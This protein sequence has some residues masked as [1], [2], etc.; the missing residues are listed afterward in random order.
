MYGA[1]SSLRATGETVINAL[2]EKAKVF[3]EH[4]SDG[5]AG[6]GWKIWEVSSN[7]FR[8]TIDELIVRKAMYV[9]ELVISKIRAIAGIIMVSPANGKIKEV[10]RTADNDGWICTIEGDNLFV[11]GDFVRC[12][13][14]HNGA[15]KDY[16]LRVR[17][18]DGQDI[19]LDEDSDYL[20]QRE[21]QAGDELVL[22]GSEVE[23]RQDY[24][25]ISADGVTAPKIEVHDK[26]SKRYDLTE[27]SN[28]T[29]RVILG[30]L[31]DFS[32]PTF[33]ELSGYGLFADNVYLKGKFLFRYTQP[34]DDGGTQTEYKTID[35]L[36]EVS[37]GKLR[38]EI[39]SE[40]LS[41]D[42]ISKFANPAFNEG[43]DKWQ[44]EGATAFK[45]GD[46]YGVR[47]ANG[48]IYQ[49]I[50]DMTK[51]SSS[52]GMAVLMETKPVHIKI[53]Y[54]RNT[55]DGKLNVSV[56][57]SMNGIMAGS[58]TGKIGFDGEITD[59]GS[60]VEIIYPTSDFSTPSTGT[61]GKK[62]ELD[63][64]SEFNWL[65]P[66]KFEVTGEVDIYMVILS[67]SPIKV[68]REK[69]SSLIKQ[70]DR[71]VQ[72][73]TQHVDKDGNIINGGFVSTTD[74]NDF[75]DGLNG[76]FDDYLSTNATIQQWNGF[77]TQYVK[78]GQLITKADMGV[79]ITTDDLG[80]AMS[81]AQIN[82]DQITFTAKNFT[83]WGDEKK[84]DKL[85]SVNEYGTMET[86]GF[87]NGGLS[88]MK[89]TIINR[90]NI[91]KYFNY[92]DGD[93]AIEI[94]RI[95]TQPKLEL[96]IKW[97]VFEETDSKTKF[98]E[99]STVYISLPSLMLGY[100]DQ[101]KATPIQS[102]QNADKVRKFIGNDLY[103]YNNTDIEIEVYGYI[104]YE[105]DSTSTTNTANKVMRKANT[106]MDQT[107]KSDGVYD[108][109]EGGYIVP[110]ATRPYDDSSLGMYIDPMVKYGRIVIKKG[111]FAALKCRAMVYM[112]V[113][114]V[115][116][117]LSKGTQYNEFYNPETGSGSESEADDS[118][119]DG[120][121]LPQEYT[122]LDYIET[123]N[124]A[125]ID[126]GVAAS[127]TIGISA[128][129]WASSK[130]DQVAMGSKGAGDS[131]VSINPST[132]NIN[133]GWN[134]WKKYSSYNA[135]LWYRTS[136]NMYNCR[137]KAIDYE[138]VD[139]ISET[140]G[141]NG[142]NIYIFAGNWDGS[143]Q[144]NFSGRISICQITDGSKLIMY[145]TPAKRTA[146][147]VCGLYD[148]IGDKFYVN[149]G[150][151][152]S[153]TGK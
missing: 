14:W 27:K 38:S 57:N 39:S 74:W 52:E 12:K 136:V 149:A 11:V 32:D 86:K 36:F 40:K 24:I 96:G 106:N 5:F 103:F 67:D 30:G 46:D 1:L 99:N 94:G 128:E 53:I 7:K 68:V 47:I 135:Q 16:W 76:Q 2:G 10:K 143:A 13:A 35:Q 102:R 44:S 34:S 124:G 137:K 65:F 107:G 109:T 49:K 133:L 100:W 79:Y 84:T 121:S 43:L 112:G 20:Y 119:L 19:I 55:N 144:H 85:M 83:L 93:G 72:F 104:I 110:T 116:W 80:K 23:D 87:L 91:E 125:Y 77:Y 150:S 25:F 108:P 6:E 21:P 90:D 70:S 42:G 132:N 101:P 31:K 117:L 61:L 64:E 148:L 123:S 18:V 63:I 82:A 145:L 26:V 75:K 146:D 129:W 92:Y 127:D 89:K 17:E 98:D 60:K 134:G 62:Y 78:D 33:G 71:L 50:E 147:N 138:A 113:E 22:M 152:G 141:A 118:A 120:K 8:L 66:I 105:S 114:C 48:Y 142:Q 122:E 97:Y 131:R 88:I 126:T 37:E 69:Y 111:D 81:E 73:A 95:F 130:V 153:F 58:S 9:Y 41:Y 115:A 139:D 140:L 3:K 4:F 15:A 54:S 45:E 29:T 56:P 59:D 151:S 28:S 51:A